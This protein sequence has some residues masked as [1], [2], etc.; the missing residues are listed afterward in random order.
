MEAGQGAE[1]VV[2]PANRYLLLRGVE[3]SA[4]PSRWAIVGESSLGRIVLENDFHTLSRHRGRALNGD[5]FP[6]TP[7]QVDAM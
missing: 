7:D 3:L 6:G 1:V 2:L 5:L 4:H